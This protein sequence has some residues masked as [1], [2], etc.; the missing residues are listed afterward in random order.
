MSE[1]VFY[2]L[3]TEVSEKVG[4]IQRRIMGQAKLVGGQAATDF[5]IKQA[6]LNQKAIEEYERDLLEKG[7]RNKA[8]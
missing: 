7:I 8:D 4:Q 6:E 3:A 5:G 1:G 2:K